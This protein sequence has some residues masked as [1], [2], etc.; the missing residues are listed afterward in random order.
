MAAYSVFRPGK[1]YI[2]QETK[3]VLGYEAIYGGDAGL[4][5]AGDPATLKLNYTTRE[6][7]VGDRL[8][9]IND[10]GYNANFFP[11]TLKNGLSGHIL[12]VA[13]GV[14]QVGQY[15]VIVLDR[16]AREGVEVG[17]LLSVYQEGETILDPV[18]PVRGDTVTLP[19]EYA[20]VALVFKTFEKVSYAI[21]M[22]AELV[23]HVGD[24]VKAL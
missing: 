4:I 15:Q 6:V 8:L 22:E 19:D 9:A 18:T 11:K 7:M 13:D 16:G 2:D 23:I 24:K 20:G 14:S 1:K 17:H 21:V 5:E 12:S 3:E 10:E